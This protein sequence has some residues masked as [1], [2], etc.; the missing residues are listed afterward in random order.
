[1]M[2]DIELAKRLKKAREAA[3]LTIGEA[4]TRLGFTNYQTLSNIEKGEREVK[5][6]ELSSFAKT[7]YCSLNNLLLNDIVPKSGGNN[8]L[9]RQAPSGEKKIE[10]EAY[11]RHRLEQ[12]HLLEKLLGIET[13][14]GHLLLSI[15]PSD[16]RTFFQIDGLAAR[17]SNLLDLGSRPAIVLQKVL[18]QVLRTKILFVELAS[19]G[20]AASTV[21]PQYGPAIVVNSEEAPWRINFTIA[22][23]LFHIL[24][25]DTYHPEE[26]TVDDGL[27]ND[28][29]RKANRFASTLLLPENEVRNELTNRIVNQKLDYADVIDVARDFGVSTQA[30]LYRLGN[31]RIIPWEKADEAAKNEEIS[32]L[33]RRIRKDGK[34]DKPISERFIILAV[35]CLRKGLISRGKFAELLEIDRPDIDDF[36]EKRGLTEIEGGA[37]EVMAS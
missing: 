13:E 33:D 17:V 31:I 4:A 11:I 20:S 22:H 15:S 37:F 6:S 21:H 29:E 30:L 7:Y 32:A 5:A 8:F 2:A 3:G 1:M 10:I 24:T 36:I 26:L 18:E 16:F 28:L 9:W 19:F 12:Y 25:W 23:E 35:K 27:A 14:T 34:N